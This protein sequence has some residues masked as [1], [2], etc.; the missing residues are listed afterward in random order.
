MPWTAFFR[1]SVD[2]VV[3][4]FLVN[5]PAH[6][7]HI[8]GFSNIY[9]RD[10]GSSGQ[11]TTL[12]RLIKDEGEVFHHDATC[13]A[14]VAA[15][16]HHVIAKVSVDN[17]RLPCPISSRIPCNKVY[18][19]CNECPN[20]G[21]TRSSF[22][23]SARTCADCIMLRANLRCR[24][25]FTCPKLNTKKIF[26][27]WKHVEQPHNK[28]ARLDC[29]VV[30]PQQD[31][32]L[33]RWLGLAVPLETMRKPLSP[34][35]PDWNSTIGAAPLEQL[36]PCDLSQTTRSQQRMHPISVSF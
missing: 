18:N 25:S 28:W 14:N 23:F 34:K 13:G 9:G 6:L 7:L 15:A 4:T 2:D 35:S 3:T 16:L 11:T 10:S 5:E 31:L 8:T 12:T 17:L 32:G 30:V 1:P 21:A 27:C 19:S 26:Q 29:Q 20:S 24:C 36:C 22:D 33:D